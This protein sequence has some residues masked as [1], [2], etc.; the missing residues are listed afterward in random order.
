MN[1]VRGAGGIECSVLCMQTAL[2]GARVMPSAVKCDA[3]GYI[4]GV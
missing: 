4:G 3:Y 1:A 2:G